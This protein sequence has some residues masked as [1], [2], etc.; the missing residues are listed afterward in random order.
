[1]F[2]VVALL[3][4]TFPLAALDVSTTLPPVQNVVGPFAVIAALGFE[5]TVTVIGC[6]VPPHPLLSVTV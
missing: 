6:D 5:F 3:L 4:H 1:M 2:C